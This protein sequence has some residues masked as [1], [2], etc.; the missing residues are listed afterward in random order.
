[1]KQLII[2]LS[3]SILV[4]CASSDQ[5]ESVA[6]ES[7]NSGRSDCISK[8]SIRD[9]RVL[10]EANLIV[11]ERGTR[12]YHV[13]LTRRAYGL[14]SS[15]GIGFDSTGG[16]V[17][18]RFDELVYEGSLG[19]EGVLIASIRRLSPEQE[20]ELLIRFGKLE[21]VDEQPRSPEK[22]EGAKVEELD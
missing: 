16:M 6:S 17:C 18:G 15:R 5:A 13:A 10:D 22:V 21:P 3:L 20:E 8:G 7:S 9:Y 4:S 11:S 12:K 19:A 14:R 1:M 2:V